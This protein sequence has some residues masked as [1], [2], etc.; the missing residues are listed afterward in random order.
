MDK[1]RVEY[2]VEGDLKLG[3]TGWLEETDLVLTDT[4]LCYGGRKHRDVILKLTPQQWK[5]LA[6]LATEQERE[7]YITEVAESEMAEYW[8]RQGED[9]EEFKLGL[10]HKLGLDDVPNERLPYCLKSRR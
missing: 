1:E 4:K 6:R 5:T 2:V 3:E 8:A 10:I 7:C 9:Y